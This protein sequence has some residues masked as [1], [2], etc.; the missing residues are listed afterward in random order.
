MGL[1]DLAYYKMVERY[2]KTLDKTM[3]PT[4]MK[5]HLDPDVEAGLTKLAKEAGVSV[6]TIAAAALY[7]VVDTKGECLTTE[8]GN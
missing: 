1:N 6:E 8:E 2:Q 7:R 4:H 5:V 3:D